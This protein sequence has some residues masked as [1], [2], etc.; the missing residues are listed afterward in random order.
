MGRGSS[1]IEACFVRGNNW[2]HALGQGRD[3]ATSLVPLCPPNGVACW[4]GARCPEPIF[5]G[6]RRTWAISSSVGA[7]RCQ[8]ARFSPPEGLLKDRSEAPGGTGFDYFVRGRNWMH[9][10]AGG[11][12]MSGHCRAIYSNVRGHENGVFNAPLK[13]KEPIWISLLNLCS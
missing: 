13:L 12:R 9:V 10:S 1:I 6:T 3:L 7:G 4:A 11:Y 5:N 2:I 8:G